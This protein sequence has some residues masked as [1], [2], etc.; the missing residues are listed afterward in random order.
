VKSPSQSIVE[1]RF[2]EKKNRKIKEDDGTSKKR[3][4]CN[5]LNIC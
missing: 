3:M 5:L 4:V 1:F 2:V